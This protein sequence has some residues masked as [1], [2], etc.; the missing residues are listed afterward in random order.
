MP[1]RCGMCGLSNFR[2][3]RLRKRDLLH[4]FLLKF[5]V[6]CRECSRRDYVSISEL[7]KIR[8]EARLRRA[9][10]ADSKNAS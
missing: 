8:Q 9:K 7:M 5:P 4:L 10:A 6:R 3:S 2:V 1:L